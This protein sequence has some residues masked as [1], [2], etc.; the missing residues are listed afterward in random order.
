MFVLVLVGYVAGANIGYCRNGVV[1]T[2]TGCVF[3]AGT[4]SSRIS[5]S[6]SFIVLSPSLIS[7]ASVVELD[8][9]LYSHPK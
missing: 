1:V 9:G 2:H 5:A 3:V 7:S 8:L 6:G 4:D